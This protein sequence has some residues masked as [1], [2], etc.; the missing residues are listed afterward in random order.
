VN[1]IGVAY[2]EIQLQKD[3]FLSDVHS[4]ESGF[5]QGAQG[6]AQSAKTATSTI[7]GMASAVVG[8]TAAVAQLRKSV[9]VVRE[10]DTAWRNLWVRMGDLSE[11]QMRTLANEIA[12][13]AIEYGHMSSAGVRAFDKIV[14]SGNSATEAMKIYRAA[15]RLGTFDNLGIEKAADSLENIMSAFRMSGDQAEELAAKLVATKRPIEEIAAAVAMVGP[16]AYGMNVSLDETLALLTVMSQ[17]MGDAG[18][19]AAGLRTTITTLATGSG[20]LGKIIQKLGFTSGRAMIE[21]LGPGKS[22]AFVQ[23][24][25]KAAGMDLEQL[26]FSSRT[27]AAAAEAA[28]AASGETAKVFKDI[29]EAGDNYAQV[30][31][32]ITGGYQFQLNRVSAQWNELL[33]A[34][35]EIILPVVL[36]IL[37]RIVPAVQ[38]M[39]LWM[40]NNSEAIQFFIKHALKMIGLVA[41]IA[42]LGKAFAL[43]SSPIVWLTAAAVAMYIAWDV[44]L[45]GIRDK[46]KKLYEALVGLLSP[47]GEFILALF[48]IED[49][50]PT[51]EALV[52][53]FTLLVGIKVV[54]WASGVVAAIAGISAGIASLTAAIAAFMANPVVLAFLGVMGLSK[55]G[56]ARE[57]IPLAEEAKK[58]WETFGVFP[59]TMAPP[60]MSKM[61]ARALGEE[62]EKAYKEGNFQEAIDAF[63]E[64]HE[65]MFATVRETVPDQADE[66]ILAYLTAVQDQIADPNASQAIR[67]ALADLYGF[68]PE[69]L[70]IPTS[71]RDAGEAYG[72]AL[73]E[74]INSLRLQ[75]SG[76]QI[77]AS[78]AVSAAAAKFSADLQA[79]F[80]SALSG[81]SMSLTAP[82]LPELV[83]PPGAIQPYQTGGAVPGQGSGDIVPAMLEPGEFV[84]PNWMM[85]IPW[86]RS[87]I[88]TIWKR[89]RAL[90]A[91]GQATKWTD[92]AAQWLEDWW[93]TGGA[94]YDVPAAQGWINALR[95]FGREVDDATSAIDAAAEAAAS[96][97]N[98]FEL[99]SFS[100]EEATKSA[101]EQMD[102][103]SGGC[104]SASAACNALAEET[105]T[106]AE[107]I[108]DISIA[109]PAKAAFQLAQ[110]MGMLDRLNIEELGAMS[111]K[112]RELVSGLEEAIEWLDTLGYPAE[113]FQQTLDAIVALFDPL[114]AFRRQLRALIYEDPR[115]VGRRIREAGLTGSTG[116]Y[117]GELAKAMRDAVAGAV[118]QP[119]VGWTEPAWTSQQNL[120]RIYGEMTAG[121]YV[122]SQEFTAWVKESGGSLQDFS[123]NVVTTTQAI[124]DLGQSA[125]AAASTTCVGGVCRR[126]PGYQYGGVVEEDGLVYVHEGETIIPSSIGEKNWAEI[127]ALEA[128]GGPQFDDEVETLAEA[129]EQVDAAVETLASTVDAA[130]VQNAAIAQAVMNATGSIQ[131]AATYSS[132]MIRTIN[133]APFA[134]IGTTSR[135]AKVSTEVLLN[136]YDAAIRALED[137]IRKLEILGMDTTQ[138]ENALVEFRAEVLGTTPELI[139]WQDWLKDAGDWGVMFNAALE[140]IPEKVTILGHTFTILSKDTRT[141][142]HD[143]LSALDARY[144]NQLA[145]TIAGDVFGSYA[146]SIKDIG[147]GLATGNWARVALGA[148]NILKQGISDAS[149]SITD[150]VDELTRTLED[151]VQIVRDAFNT[152]AGWTEAAFNR[153]R[154]AANW[155]GTNLQKVGT[156]VVSVLMR[157][158]DTLSSIVRQ[159]EQMAM[160][161]ADLAAVQKG[162][163]SLLLGFLWPIAAVL[164]QIAGLFGEAEEQI[165]QGSL[166]VPSGWNVERAEYKAAT[167]GEP[168]LSGET[169][170]D[171]LPAWLRGIVEK[172]QDAIEAILEPIRQFIQ[173]L[174]DLWQ[175]I[176]PSV[177][178][179]FL[180]VIQTLVD[181]LQPIADWMLE[182]LLPDLKAFF[183][184]FAV[185]WKAE[186]EPF[187]KSQVFPKLGEWFVALYELLRDEIIPYLRD[188]MFAFIVE[189]WPTV[190]TIVERVGGAFGALWEVVVQAL[191]PGLRLALAATDTFSSALDGISKWIADTFA[192]DLKAIFDSL[193]EWWKNDVDPFL[194][195]KVFVELGKWME[196]LW[197]FLADDLI[198]FLVQDVFGMLRQQWPAIVKLADSVANVLAALWTIVKENLIPVVN[199]GISVLST[200]AAMVD[201][202]AI[203]M[204]DT[205]AK[206]LRE[207]F[208]ALLEWWRTQVDPFLRSNVFPAI[209]KALEDVWNAVVSN[210]Q[211]MLD[212]IA[213]SLRNLWP[214]AE[215]VLQQL[216]P[217][218]EKLLTTIQDNW[219]AIERIIAQWIDMIPKQLSSWI[220][221]M[222]KNIQKVDKMLTLWDDIQNA[223]KYVAK[224]LLVAGGAVIGFFLGGPLGAAIGAAL[225]LAAAAAVPSGKT[226]SSSSSA[227]GSSG[228]TSGGSGSSSG[229]SS[230]SSGGSSGGA[231]SATT[232]PVASSNVSI[233][234]YKTAEE[235]WA[236]GY[237]K[238]SGMKDFT[239]KEGIYKSR[240]I[241]ASFE[242][243]LKD[244]LASGYKLTTAQAQALWNQ[245]PGA[246]KGGIIPRPTMVLAG[247]AGPEA[248]IPLERFSRY[249]MGDI[250]IN[251]IVTLD[252]EVVYRSVQRRA[253]K[254]NMRSGYNLPGVPA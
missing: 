152:V 247:E 29:Q 234:A 198:P 143:F 227:S 182:T 7:V 205:F 200:F 49:A 89:G 124:R 43:L 137:E 154:D 62:L 191:I 69:E 144:V 38:S 217:L 30:L 37:N 11:N 42:L 164:H 223:L 225:G 6:I 9:Q 231:T 120:E 238:G 148:Y 218:F 239:I 206:D 19:A 136:E 241:T 22:L 65:E 146:G 135:A 194:K 51:V 160:I 24:A 177:I 254:D 16:V 176:A 186:V 109:D 233:Y 57:A 119:L 187:L 21:Q 3:K 173:A 150:T 179:A 59:T 125:Q 56:Q 44:N 215:R 248:I 50:T 207:I 18:A 85:R 158:G 253:A 178:T 180:A 175:A 228:S 203:W 156:T 222:S 145:D 212:L 201:S 219:P 76:L 126:V 25:A 17:T 73:E 54:S 108:R 162:F 240:F 161:Q 72:E 216:G 99:G 171:K 243:F 28:N 12:D 168:A 184:G 151:G 199:L 61:N 246:A 75:V 105:Q 87:L 139:R 221:G 190:A 74:T 250:T 8:L 213:Q 35:G 100:L 91:G 97:V 84:V 251:N 249:P 107:M 183:E 1:R 140:A 116:E 134:E 41:G 167:P 67:N 157:F 39:A 40:Q 118:G 83:L 123:Q 153:V 130:A 244:A 33:I 129:V 71:A 121:G 141:R 131:T 64:V 210:M 202:V 252:G 46:V 211:P 102:G 117:V 224:A 138:A 242:D 174:E 170:Q 220:D 2:A 26:G 188:N 214:H 185:W 232:E 237:A 112:Y 82:S 47:I 4:A 169:T 10:F 94:A 149:Q 172:F 52:G 142:V 208:G 245:V 132:P 166:N 209:Q 90:Q 101:T 229:G 127:M 27:Y 36:Q 70:M 66:I 236:Q 110:L 31:E 159:T 20:D 104:S 53:A 23:A 58:M 48:G 93:I 60:E 163:L 88:E 115:E 196:R 204:R 111:G 79:A 63:V 86:L 68:T 195:S 103:L 189:A 81:A 92:Q 147:G 80:Q 122:P 5:R 155:L 197:R 193:L 77:D 96:F 226:S 98:D 32:K 15:A 181:M 13:I 113:K 45:Y 133:Q 114:D 192:A 14:Q 106:L 165:Y 235:L 95:S 78:M 34:L 230:G 55:E 128:A